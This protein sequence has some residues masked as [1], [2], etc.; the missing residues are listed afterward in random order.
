MRNVGSLLLFL[1]ALAAG[2]PVV[3]LTKAPTAFPHFWKRC[4]G[5]GHML[6]A[7]RADWQHHLVRARDELGFTG[8][9]GHGLLDDDMSVMPRKGQYEFFNVD[10]VF[11]FLLSAKIKPVVELSFTPMA[12]VECAPENCSYA[13][14]NHAAYKG[15]T[16]PPKDFGEWEELIKTLTEHFVDRYGL[17]EVATW[18]FEVWN[19]LW[20]MDFPHPYMDLYASSAR[21]LK[22]VSPRLRVGGPATMQVL[23]VEDFVDAAQAANLPIDFVSTHLYPTDPECPGGD[24]DCFTRLIHNARDIVRNKTDAEFLITEYNAGLGLKEGLDLDAP[25]GAAF[26]FRQI[27]AI[28]DVDMFSWWTFTDIFEEQWM[29]S[30][31]FNNGFGLQ[32]IHGVAKPAWRAFQLLKD[33][34]SWRVPVTGANPERLNTSLSVLATVDRVDDPREFQL[35]VADWSPAD[36]TR[37]SCAASGTCVEDKQGPYTDEALCNA[38]CGRKG[39][40]GGASNTVAIVVKHGQ[41]GLLNGRAFTYSLARIDNTHGNAKA[42]WEAMGRPGYLN[43]TQIASLVAASQLEEEDDEAV[44]KVRRVDGE[45]SEVTAVLPPWSAA[46]VVIRAAS[47][48]S[49]WV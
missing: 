9:R 26:A 7:T 32:T 42:S 16:M 19:E 47:D 6:L 43:Q 15:L 27:A 10:T 29:K 4:V 2:K 40:F 46:R 48:A 17:E 49:Y 30:Q 1:S 45:T 35:F 20:G 3:D 22:A 5:T 25:F 28:Q 38:Q 39:A 23:H 33:A 13:F 24:V 41:A 37:F 31:P 36:T 34:G 11:D 21:A 44:V 12:L 8:I 18:D 14:N